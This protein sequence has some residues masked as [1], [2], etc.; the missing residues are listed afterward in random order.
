MNIYD[1][2]YARGLFGSKKANMKIQLRSF[3]LPIQG[4]VV[5]RF[6]GYLCDVRF[7]AIQNE[8]IRLKFQYTV[9]G[10]KLKFMRKL[11]N[12]LET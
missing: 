8:P 1:T 12:A 4:L 10:H 11:E 5:I 3:K 6:R 2:K 9:L 7:C